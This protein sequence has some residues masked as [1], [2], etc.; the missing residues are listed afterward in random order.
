MPDG[1]IDAP[2]AV[3]VECLHARDV[4]ADRRRDRRAERVRRHGAAAASAAAAG[5]R[6]RREAS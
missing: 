6:D 2:V 3:D 4:G 1:E 5:K